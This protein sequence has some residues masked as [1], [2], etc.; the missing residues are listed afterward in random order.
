[1]SFPGPIELIVIGVMLLVTLG[2]PLAILVSLI[3][4]S[5]RKDRE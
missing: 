1:M 2:I 3:F 5:R 4:F